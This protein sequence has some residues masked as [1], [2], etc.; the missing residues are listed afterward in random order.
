V[1]VDTGEYRAIEA[2]AEALGN[3]VRA[4]D[5]ELHELRWRH[6]EMLRGRH[7]TPRARR[8]WRPLDGFWWAGHAEAMGEVAG[9]IGA[10]LDRAEPSP[11]ILLAV[12]DFTGGVLELQAADTAP[13][14]W[15]DGQ[16]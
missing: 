2:G 11:V 4:L 10:M 9:L 5:G 12:A 13:A 16:R 14:E 8:R 15:L 1:N 7:R 6:A 3:E